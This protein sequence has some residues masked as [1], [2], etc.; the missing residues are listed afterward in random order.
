MR[1]EDVLKVVREHGPLTVVEILDTLG[2]DLSDKQVKRAMY[3]EAHQCI[4][5]LEKYDLIQ[6]VA[7]GMKG[8]NVP[9]WK[10]GVVE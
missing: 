5:A 2:V 8:Y 3:S 10:W 7:S 1:Q 9:R 6:K 4:R